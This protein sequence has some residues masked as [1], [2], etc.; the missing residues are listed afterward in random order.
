MISTVDG[1]ISTVAYLEICKGREGFP[2]EVHFRCT[3]YIF[4]KVKVSRN[5]PH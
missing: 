1:I 5:F 3:V 2:G 4:R